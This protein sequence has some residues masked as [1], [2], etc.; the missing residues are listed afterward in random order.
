[1]KKI[2]KNFKKI[3]FFL[4]IQKKCSTF[5]PKTYADGDVSRAKGGFSDILNSVY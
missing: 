1:M 4:R 2:S 5:A 3:T